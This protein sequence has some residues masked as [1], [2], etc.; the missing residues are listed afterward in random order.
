MSK[1]LLIVE[2]PAKAKTIEKYLG[3]D[4]TVKASMGHIR[5]LP[6]K[7]DAVDIENNFKP[8]YEVSKDKRDVVKELKKLAKDADAVWLATDEDREGEAISWHLAEVLGL[9]VNATKRIVFSE[10]TKSAIQKAVKEPRQLDMHL[11][12]AQQA[13]RILDR[14]V[15]FNLSPVLWKKV[16]GGLSAGRVQSVTVRLIVEREHEIMAFEPSP[17]FRVTAEFKLPSGE[18]IK[19]ELR[20]K[21]PDYDTAM[22]FLQMCLGSAFKVDDV[23]ERPGKKSPAPPFTTSTLQQEASRKLSFP[24]G[25]TMSVAQRL[26]ENGHITYMRTD[27]VNLS[28]EALGKMTNTIKNDYGEEYHQFRRFKSKSSGAQEAHEAIRPTDFNKR[29]VS[30]DDRQQRLYDLIWKRAIASQMADAKLLRTTVNIKVVADDAAKY[31]NFVTKGEVV[32]FDGFLKVYLEGTD[33]EGEGSATQGLLP[34]MKEGDALS[35]QNITATERFTN[36]PPRYTEASLVKKLEELGI[37]RP[38]TYAPTIST[39][40]N[41][42]YVEKP[43]LQGKKRNYRVL[44]MADSKIDEQKD[45]ETTGAGRNKLVPSD[46]GILVTQFLQENFPSIMD[47][48]FTAKVEGD[49]DEVAA[50][51]IEWPK[52]IEDFYVPFKEK[53][54]DTTENAERVS[55]ERYLGDDP[56]T[57]KPII[58]RLGRYGPLVQLGKQ[59]DE[60]KKFAGLRKNQRLETVTLEEALDLFKLPRDLGEYEG[61]AVNASIGRFGPYIRH[62]GKF[63]SIKKDSGDDPYTIELDRAIELIE[64]KREADRKKL[65]KEFEDTEFKVLNGRWG[66]YVKHGK[67]NLK[68]SKEQK[69]NPKDLTLEDVQKLLDEYN[70]GGGKK[71]RGK[72]KTTK[73]KSTAKKKTTAK[74]STAKKKTTAKK[75]TTKKKPAAKKTTTAKKT[76]KKKSTSKTSDNA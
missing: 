33:D 39:V 59:E 11:V 57:G 26:Y 10:I 42:G 60:D 49:F 19:S 16:K 75:S 7:D 35:A 40:M 37:G 67:T 73:K 24:V 47:Y 61:K 34:K 5:D 63:V 64:E 3:K 25:M 44:K 52:L 20:D 21:L 54:E 71:G 12:N 68:L 55:G 30:A 38:S 53:V 9:D 6:K 15:G 51:Q 69:E 72:K 41:R 23:K 14:L 28:N 74:K 48:D 8:R 18:L 58:A 13:R 17:Y 43:E 36:P 70:A 22:A 50:G 65:I 46:M 66:P 4:F 29:R 56:K 1:N 27:S 45:T 62:D 2:S 32:T 31:P 76:T